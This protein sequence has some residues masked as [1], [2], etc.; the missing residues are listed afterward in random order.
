MKSKVSQMLH[1]S[2]GRLVI[3]VLLGLGLASLFKKTCNSKSCYKFVAP[4]VS[5][6]TSSVYSHGGS[7][8][9]FKPITVQCKNKESILFA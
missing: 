4:N 3:S 7:C 1:T 6:I 5:E 9:T 2:Y 8:Y